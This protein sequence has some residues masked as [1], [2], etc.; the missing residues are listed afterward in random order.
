MSPIVKPTIYCDVDGVINTT[1][2][3]ENGTTKII[4]R[5]LPSLGE[6]LWKIPLRI[7]W[8]NHTTLT[9][10]ALQ[11][12][13]YWLTTWNHQAVHILE[14]LIGIKSTGV[15]PYRMP[16]K[17]ARRQYTKYELL[18]AHQAENPS[19]FIWIDDVA[20]QHYKKEH[21]KDAQPHLIIR[22]NKRLGITPEHLQQIHD[23]VTT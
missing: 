23:F 15:I 16:L 3:L 1:Q 10:A 2:K 14:P 4:Y 5:K 21:F 11:V 12:N 7:N 8:H 6:K 18:K 13:F 17:E 20:T 19:P 22:T 9:L